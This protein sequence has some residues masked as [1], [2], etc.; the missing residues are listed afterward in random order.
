MKAKLLVLASCCCCNK[1]GQTCCHYLTI[2][3]VRSPKQVSRD[4][5]HGALFPIKRK[6]G[7]PCII[8]GHGKSPIE[9]RGQIFIRKPLILHHLMEGYERSLPPS[10]CQHTLLLPV[11]SLQNKLLKPMLMARGKWNRMVKI[12]PLS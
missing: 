10:A 8:L 7:G 3:L 9:V 11:H 1:L 4:Q 6:N 2:L 5:K 12:P